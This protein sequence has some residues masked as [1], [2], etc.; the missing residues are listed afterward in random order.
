MAKLQKVSKK[1]RMFKTWEATSIKMGFQSSEDGMKRELWK[2]SLTDEKLAKHLSKCSGKTIEFT[3][4]QSY[5]N[6]WQIAKTSYI[7]TDFK[8][9]NNQ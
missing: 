2:F 1:G 7:V 5:W 8:I 3:Y 4:E 9:I 6:S